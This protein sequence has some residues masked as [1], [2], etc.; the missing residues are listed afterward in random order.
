MKLLKWLI[1]IVIVGLLLLW[2][3]LSSRPDPI[4]VS[5]ASVESGTVD[6]T[7]ANTRAG[8]IKACRRAKMSPSTG[9]QIS[10]LHFAEGQAVKKGDTL[11]E[12]WN[13]DL[14][15]QLNLSQS[16][17]AA[18]QDHAQAACVQ[19]G[20]AKK[21]AD[22]MARLKANAHISSEQYDQSQAEASVA[23]A[24]CK[25]ARANAS[26]AESQISVARAQLERTILYAPF[27]GVIANIN[28]ELN[29][30]VTPSPVG[31]Q[32]PPVVDLIAPGCFLVTAPIDEVDAPRVEVGMLARITLDAWRGRDF[33]GVVTRIGSYVVDREKQAR[34]VDVELTFLSADDFKDLLVGYS[35]DVDIITE[36][37]DDVLRI[38][39][40]SLK[41][42][43]S[44]LLYD[45]SG[46]E[47]QQRKIEKGLS[48]WSWVEVT[49]GLQAGDQVVTSLGTEGVEAGAS[50]AVAD[51]IRK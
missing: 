50:V 3:L 12:L 19:A 5:L 14:E 25:A 7:V 41:D 30:Y 35:A 16:S 27:D 10:A 49:A 36:S 21:T 22:R 51:E 8:T 34:T 33:G 38:P 20:V 1:L 42:E 40:Q 48:N 39:A 29:E 28:G 18:A 6:S 24:E 44:V 9:G 32:T 31:V 11:L 23:E 26:V 2:L 46:G 17:L 4:E 15:A 37:R 43:N 13:D 47:L 45:A